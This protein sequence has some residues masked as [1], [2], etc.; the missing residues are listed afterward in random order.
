MTARALHH[1]GRTHDP[2]AESLADALQ[3]QAHAEDGK[4]AGHLCEHIVGHPGVVGYAG[5]GADQDAIGLGPADLVNRDGI[6]AMYFRSRP[7]FPE[8]LHEY[9]YERV[10]VV[11]DEN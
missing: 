11:D 9:V 7:E 6:V 4:L 8:I 1:V 10:V 3:A 2:G 5:P